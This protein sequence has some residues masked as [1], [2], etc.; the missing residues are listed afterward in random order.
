MSLPY[1]LSDVMRNIPNVDPNTLVIGKS[2][3]YSDAD[4]SVGQYANSYSVISYDSAAVA[5]Q[6]ELILGTPIGTEQ[7]EPLLGSNVLLFLFDAS[8]QSTYDAI[9]LE[10]LTALTRW[11]G[12]RLDFYSAS[13]YKDSDDN[14]VI[15]VPFKIKATGVVGTYVGN[16]TNMSS[17]VTQQ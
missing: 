5:G 3:Y 15:A 6:I 17:I 2:F 11:L 7:H 8:I 9:Q 16:L 10:A 14:V 4:P 13:V 12:G 1:V